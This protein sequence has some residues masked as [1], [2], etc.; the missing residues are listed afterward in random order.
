MLHLNFQGFAEKLRELNKQLEFRNSLEACFFPFMPR[1]G[2]VIS[3]TSVPRV[4][5]IAD[6]SVSKPKPE[7]SPTRRQICQ[8]APLNENPK[9]MCL[10]CDVCVF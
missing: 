2:F 7:T 6:A 9:H 3:D 4:G 8:T 10:V 5:D 1:L